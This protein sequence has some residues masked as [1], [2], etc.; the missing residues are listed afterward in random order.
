MGEEILYGDE[1]GSQA[2]IRV[3][4]MRAI[5]GKDTVRQPQSG[6]RWLAVSLE[7]ANRGDRAFIVTF[8][9][10]KLA[11]RQGRIYEQ[12]LVAQ[13]TLAQQLQPIPPGQVATGEVAF[14][15]P[16]DANAAKLVYDPLADSCESHDNSLSKFYPCDRFPAIVKLKPK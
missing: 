6:N 4:G 12:S 1:L 3:T 8:E 11:D 16:K 14:E 2:R 15:L 7:I 10:M 5:E 13:S 9:Q